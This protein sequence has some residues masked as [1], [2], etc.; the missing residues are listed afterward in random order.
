MSITNNEAKLCMFLKSIGISGRYK[1]FYYLKD[2]VFLVLENERS[3]CNIQQE[4]YQPI[5]ETYHVSVS[6]I[7]RAIRT[8]C[9]AASQN[10]EKIREFFPG[11]FSH[12]TLYPKELI[13]MAADYLRYH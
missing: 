10:E 12:G 1:G 7:A 6:S 2:A 5:A 9:Q 8:V 4:I 11:F 13:E 3:L